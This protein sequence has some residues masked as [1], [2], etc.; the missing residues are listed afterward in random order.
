[1]VGAAFLAA[2]CE[3]GVTL[4]GTITV[5]LEVQQAFSQQRP[6]LVRIST[7]IPKTSV[8][9]YR[10][11]VLCEPGSAP[12]VLTFFHDGVGCAKEGVVRIDVL[13]AAAGQTPACGAG[14][15]PWG[16]TTEGPVV[17]TGRAT[18]FEGV[19]G[20]GGCPSGADSIDVVLT[21]VR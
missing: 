19:T 3:H 7:S 5:P 6:G 13:P 16:T 20:S 10:L 11:A 1:V 17:A 18:V 15:T 14:Q 2:A 21:L 12:L 9:D 8:L 4:H